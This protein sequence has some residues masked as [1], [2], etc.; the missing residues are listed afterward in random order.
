M[1]CCPVV[2]VKRQPL[3]RQTTLNTAGKFWCH[4][5]AH[6]VSSNDL[7][8]SKRWSSFNIHEKADTA[9]VNRTPQKQLARSDPPIHEFYSWSIYMVTSVLRRYAEQYR[10]MVTT[11]RPIWLRDTEV[12]RRPIFRRPSTTLISERKQLFITVRKAIY[13]VNNFSVYA[14]NM[15]YL[16]TVMQ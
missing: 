4:T 11:D 7:P 15:M 10:N 16:G 12:I 1:V 2:T 6:V 14:S 5:S 13:L 8:A 9:D 3:W